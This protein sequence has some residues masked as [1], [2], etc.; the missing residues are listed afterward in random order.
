[1]KPVTIAVSTKEPGLAQDLARGLTGLGKNLIVR[2]VNPD[3]NEGDSLEGVDVIAADF[4][5]CGES[6][7]TAP[8]WAAVTLDRNHLRISQVYQQI[9]DAYCENREGKTGSAY[10]D[11]TFHCLSF[12]SMQGGCGVTAVAVTAGR[13]LAGMYG[14][15]TLYVPVTPEDGSMLYNEPL[16]TED[17]KNRSSVLL[18]ELQYRIKNAR[19]LYMERFVGQDEYGLEY[20]CTGF[21]GKILMEMKPDE[22]NKLL[23]EIAERGQ[24]QWMLLDWGKQA[25]TPDFG[26]PAE[27]CSGEDSR[28]GCLY[29]F[30]RNDQNKVAESDSQRIQ[31]RNHGRKNS[32][33]LVKDGVHVEIL[34]DEESFSCGDEMGSSSN[35]EISMSKSFSEG[36]RNLVELLMGDSFSLDACRI[37]PIGVEI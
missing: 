9:M 6:G 21:S 35:V 34:H 16:M 5:F 12:F 37:P 31:I 28:T 1:M 23:Q 13:M 26:V 29:R 8:D 25:E 11:G 24:Y 4:D 20:L 14:E 33:E 27:V 18:K 30:D 36:V 2:I 7:E 22:R 32:A 3:F 17:Q 10:G 19:P 15:K